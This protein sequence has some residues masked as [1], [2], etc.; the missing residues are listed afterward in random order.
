MRTYAQIV[1]QL[2]RVIRSA[3]LSDIHEKI[4]LFGLDFCSLL[5][6]H[7]IFFSLHE[8][9]DNAYVSSRAAVTSL[10]PIV[11]DQVFYYYGSDSDPSFAVEITEPLCIN[12][13]GDLVLKDQRCKCG[14]LLCA[15]PWSL[16]HRGVV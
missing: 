13:D 3:N 9:Q 5:D 11:G 6:D 10:K 7:L 16:H 2:Y 15:G 1:R 14:S 4:D 8:L 12:A